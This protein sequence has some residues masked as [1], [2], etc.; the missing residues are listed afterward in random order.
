MN[1]DEKA[2][3]IV[4]KIT[5]G[6]D[7][8]WNENK[9]QYTSDSLHMSEYHMAF[10]VWQAAAAKTL[11]EILPVFVKNYRAHETT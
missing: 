9:E 1:T 11:E 7:T 4:N 10:T 2:R 6:F 8:W 5:E 3:Q